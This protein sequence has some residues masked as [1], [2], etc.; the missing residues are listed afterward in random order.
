MFFRAP[1]KVEQNLFVEARASLSRFIPLPFFSRVVL[2]YV[3]PSQASSPS[4]TKFESVA[5]L[6]PPGEAGEKLIAQYLTEFQST[7]LGVK[8]DAKLVSASTRP[9]P[10][11]VTVLDAEVNV[12]SFANEQ[13]YGV[14][15]ENRG[16]QKLEWDRRL[17]ATLAVANGRLYALRMQCNEEDL[18]SARPQFDAVRASFT[19]FPVVG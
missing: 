7:R 8:R 5:Q 12:K 3:F 17:F 18:A 14:S 16:P 15:A 4:S 13:Q 9:G 1:L 11:G 19:A 10:G 2:V 6:G